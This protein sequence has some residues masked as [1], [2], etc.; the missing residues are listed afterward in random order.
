[1]FLFQFVITPYNSLSDAQSLLA[2]P[3]VFFSALGIVMVL[4]VWGTLY[5][6]RGILRAR[7]LL[8]RSFDLLEAIFFSDAAFLAF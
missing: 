4:V 5:L 7:T 8:V 1:M 2:D 6:I 3:G